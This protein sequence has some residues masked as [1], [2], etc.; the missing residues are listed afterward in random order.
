MHAYNL[1][2]ICLNSPSRQQCVPQT[3]QSL[4]ALCLQALTHT[5]T[6]ACTHSAAT[7]TAR[8]GMPDQL[9][10]TSVIAALL[11]VLKHT[12]SRLPRQSCTPHA[13]KDEEAELDR[14]TQ[15][16]SQ[17]D[18]WDNELI[19]TAFKVCCRSLCLCP[20]PKVSWQHSQ[21]R[22]AISALRRPLTGHS[23]QRWTLHCICPAVM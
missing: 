13:V 23:Q 5:A 8:L 18:I 21:H 9:L 3:S 20:H 16:A 17:A 15:Q 22:M 2:F 10:I 14:I 11:Q 12:V 1:M 7:H 4:H 19:G 6:L